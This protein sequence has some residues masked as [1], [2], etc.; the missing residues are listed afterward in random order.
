[1][2]VVGSRLC[3]AAGG[4]HFAGFAKRNHSP[5]VF[6]FRKMIVLK[7]PS[8]YEIWKWNKFIKIWCL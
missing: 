5:G 4:S 2:I 7:H 6:N 1:M 8:V 3:E